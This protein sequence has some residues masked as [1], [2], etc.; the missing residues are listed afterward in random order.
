MPPK[1]SQGQKEQLAVMRAKR[2]QEGGPGP[3]PGPSQIDESEEVQALK[4]ALEHKEAQLQTEQENS[5]DL[6]KCLRVEQ[7]KVSCTQTAKAS[8]RAEADNAG[9]MVE[10]LGQRLEQ[11]SFKN[12]QLERTISEQ[13]EKWANESQITQEKLVECRK[14]ARALQARCTRA[15]EILRKAVERA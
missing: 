11:L 12:E 5:Q 10:E 2:R 8:A 14:K 7:C 15:P 1:R 13:L 3:N 9:A 6:Y 4:L